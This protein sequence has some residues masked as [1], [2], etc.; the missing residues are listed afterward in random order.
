MENTWNMCGKYMEHRWTCG[1][2]QKHLFVVLQAPY[3]LA[4][5]GTSFLC[6]QSH[7]MPSMQSRP[8][9]PRQGAPRGRS[10]HHNSGNWMICIPHPTSRVTYKYYE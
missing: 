10:A 4:P 3:D 8:Y 5:M 2:F 6:H 9:I 7:L 1:R